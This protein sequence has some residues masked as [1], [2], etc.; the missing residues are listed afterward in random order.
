M[1]GC[2]RSARVAAEDDAAI[3]YDDEPRQM[4][5]GVEHRLGGAPETQAQKERRIRC[6]AQFF[7]AAVRWSQLSSTV[8]DWRSNARN[9]PVGVKREIRLP[10]LSTTPREDGSQLPSPAQPPM[11]NEVADTEHE[12][13]IKARVYAM[14]LQQVSDNG[15]TINSSQL[16]FLCTQ[17]DINY[18]DVKHDKLV[19][20]L[21]P[22]QEDCITFEAFYRWLQ[23]RNRKKAAPKQ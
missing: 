6:L 1:G 23:K 18:S 2:C 20:T 15:N 13:Q 21:D 4:D 17:L 19:T 11:Q 7:M 10:P 5:A 16:R 8:W 14:F 9:V 3:E 22:H 12:K